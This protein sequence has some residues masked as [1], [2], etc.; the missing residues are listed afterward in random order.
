MNNIYS[1]INPY[2]L[3]IKNDFDFI[4]INNVVGTDMQCIPILTRTLCT[5]G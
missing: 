5:L 4:S 3:L 2:A 1:I